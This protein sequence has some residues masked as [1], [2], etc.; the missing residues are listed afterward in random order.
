MTAVSWI[1]AS[2]GGK[3]GK[4]GTPVSDNKGASGPET[5]PSIG[6]DFGTWVRFMY[7][8]MCNGSLEMLSFSMRSPST[9]PHPCSS[10]TQ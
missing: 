1:M 9:T 4:K 5:E 8:L 6:I 3:G 10:L 2:R 7:S